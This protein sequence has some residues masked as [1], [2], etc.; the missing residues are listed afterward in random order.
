QCQI[1]RG[2]GAWNHWMS[3]EGESYV[4]ADQPKGQPMRSWFVWSQ[5]QQNGREILSVNHL[6]FDSIESLRRGLSFF[7][8]LKDQYWAVKL[9]LPADLQLFRLLKETQ[10]PQRPTNHETAESKYFTRMQVRV[11]DHQ[12]MINSLRSAEYVWGHV[13]IAH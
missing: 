5:Q 4:V 6:A 10:V 12:R 8:T 3:N 9:T 13:T 7:A 1:E 2:D 11:L